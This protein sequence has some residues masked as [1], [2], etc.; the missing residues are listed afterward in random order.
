MMGLVS[1]RHAAEVAKDLISCDLDTLTQTLIVPDFGVLWVGCCEFFMTC[2]NYL[3]KKPLFYCNY[4]V[5][6]M[7]ALRFGCVLSGLN[8]IV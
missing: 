1:L 3:W 6:R 7:Y 2:T 4:S 8:D 5:N